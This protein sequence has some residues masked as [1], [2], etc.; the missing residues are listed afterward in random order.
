VS[1]LKRHLS[2]ANVLSLIALFV[3]L[4]GVA[5]AAGKL[6]PG[7]VK[8]VNIANQAVTNPKIKT[9]AVTSGK[10]KNSG[11]KAVDLGPGSVTNSKLAKKAVTNSKL[12]TESVWNGNLAKKAVTENKLGAE[13][14]STGKLGNE[15]VTSAKISSSTWHQ[16]LKNT[17]YV[18]VTSGPQENTAKTIVALCP[19]GKEAI[20]GGFRVT[21]VND[22][23]MANE[24][25]P[26][27]NSSGA[28]IGWSASARDL[29][30][31]SGSWTLL[32]YAVCAEL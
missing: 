17:T 19:S 7:A 12:G 27:F 5:V 31:K 30:T 32:A 18:T 4:S 10:I 21:G 8:S 23:V 29:E 22:D 13:S 9:Q 16:L 3:A 26:E 28:R 2:A 25:A 20:G 6:G 24:S 15:S 14:V 11:I 1:M